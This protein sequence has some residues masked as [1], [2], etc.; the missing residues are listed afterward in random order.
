MVRMGSQAA[1][2]RWNGQHRRLHL[3]GWVVTC[4]FI[5]GLL[6]VHSRLRRVDGFTCLFRKWPA[7]VNNELE[8]N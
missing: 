3:T 4:E 6:V 2:E 5:Y 1:E 7:E 8:N